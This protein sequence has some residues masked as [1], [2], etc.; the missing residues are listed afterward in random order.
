M[1]DFL[2]Q[3][4]QYVKTTAPTV[5]VRYGQIVVDPARNEIVSWS[6]PGVPQPSDVTVRAVTVTDS[7]TRPPADTRTA[8]IEMAEQ[9]RVLEATVQ[10][11]TARIVTL[12]SR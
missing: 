11:L 6:V 3:C 12:E 10:S 8:I 7:L 1:T 2:L 5:T 9:I 4:L